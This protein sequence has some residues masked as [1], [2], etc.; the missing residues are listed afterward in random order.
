MKTVSL[1]F[2]RITIAAIACSAL[3]ILSFCNQQSRKSVNSHEFYGT[4][5]IDFQS[6]YQENKSVIN[7]LAPADVEDLPE[8]M[9]NFF[10]KS[11]DVK[12][13]FNEDNTGEI[14]VDKNIKRFLENLDNG[15][16]SK[17]SNFNYQLKHDS[18]LTIKSDDGEFN[19]FAILH[20]LSNQFDSLYFSIIGEEDGFRLLLR[21]I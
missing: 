16:F 18:I 1:L 20:R 17:L 10:L 21:K 6:F 15:D 7:N 3:V 5:K 11:L 14:I 4:Y 9:I 19:D 13:S 8:S 12:L 2:K